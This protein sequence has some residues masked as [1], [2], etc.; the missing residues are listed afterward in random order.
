[1]SGPPPPSAYLPIGDHGLI[2]DLHTAA[3]V[4]R[5]GAIDWW[6]APRF[7]APS[8]FGALLDAAGGGHWTIAPR[9][10]WTS[11]Q[12]YLP[13]T[14]VLVTTFHTDSGGVAALT[15]FMPLPATRGVGS[16][17]HRRVGCTRGAVEVEVVFAPRFGY[18]AQAPELV[19]RRNGVLAT[20]VE[21]DVA[22]LAAPTGITWTVKDGR[23]AAHLA[24]QAG[25]A[26]WLVLRYDDDEVHPIEYYASNDRLDATARWWDAWLAQL[27]YRGPYRQEVERSALVLKLCCYDPS[28]AIIGAP[29]TSL[30]ESAGGDRNWDYRFVWL[31]DAAFVLYGL[32]RLGFGSEVDGFLAFLK[33]VSRRSD[34]RHLQIM[35]GVDGRRDLPEQVLPHLE[36]YRGAR[37]VRIGNGA[38]AQFQL[39]IYGELLETVALWYRRGHVSEGLW[40]VLRQLVDWT[41]GHWREPDYSIWES[42]QE[43]KHFVF[44]KVMA[45][46]ALDRGARIA[47]RL[48][49]AADVEAWRREAR[50]VHAEV[51]E[52]GWDAER[53]TFVQVYGEPQLDA[54]VLIIPNLGFL[55]RDD[56]RVRS[57]LAAVRREL[58]SPSEDLIYRYRSPDGLGGHEGA[59]VACSF[60]MVQNLALVG[61][62]AEAERLFKNLLRRANHL[63][64][65]AEEIDPNSGEQ[66]GNFPQA[67]SH[68]ALLGTAFILER[69]RPEEPGQE[70]GAT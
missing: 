6:C 48:S 70:S 47:E 28:G 21:D 55:R 7:D 29:T 51:L 4:G 65:L 36:G 44:S 22:T 31:R 35:Y 1:M 27:A 2:G 50:A 26:V 12:R 13:A 46:A 33:R 40:K 56:P 34:G 11:E 54:A 20:D 18:G 59:F 14:N 69:M 43:P 19:L 42:R 62:F 3:L 49:L 32:E 58:A 38:A 63:G 8:I 52:R 5:N 57:T 41:A 53:E 60:W 10:P 15:D 39:D 17:I 9:G 68:A 45:W 66:L 30:P 64:L 16:E 23:A 24:L 61:E 67:L 37:P 25:E